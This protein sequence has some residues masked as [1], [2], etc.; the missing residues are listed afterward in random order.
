MDRNGRLAILKVHTRKLKVSEELDLDRVSL[1][2]PGTSGAEL[3]A[4][5]NEGVGFWGVLIRFLRC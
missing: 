3:C 4:I 1:V 2:T 5:V